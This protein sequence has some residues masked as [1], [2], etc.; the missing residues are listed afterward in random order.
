MGYE[1]LIGETITMRGHNGDRIEAYQARPIGLTGV[2]GVVVIHHMPGWDEW[3]K[4]VACAAA[5]A[6]AKSVIGPGA[7]PGAW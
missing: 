7:T 5:S 4:E 3:T 6:G 1:G 2:P